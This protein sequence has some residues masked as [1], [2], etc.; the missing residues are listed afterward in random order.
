MTSGRRRVSSAAAC[1]TRGAQAE[2]VQRRCATD[3]ST[4]RSERSQQP[5]ERGT[6]PAGHQLAFQP[7]MAADPADVEVS[8]PLG[9]GAQRRPGRGRC[10]RPYRRP[11]SGSASFQVPRAWVSREMDSR[12]P[13]AAKLT[14][15]DEPPELTNGSV[16]PVIGISR[17]HDADVDEGLERQP[18]RDAHRQQAAEGVRRAE[19]DADAPV[20]EEEEEARP[21]RRRRP[22]RTPGRPRRR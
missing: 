1:G 14:T 8:V 10:G 9:E 16:M 3:R 20:G 13:T 15:S 18:R 5:V 4:V 17:Q 12:I 2:R 21:P 6:R 7:A 19:R 22:A 11:R